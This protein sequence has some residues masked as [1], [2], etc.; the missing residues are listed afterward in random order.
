M[1]DSQDAEMRTHD[2]RNALAAMAAIAAGVGLASEASAQIIKRTD[3]G[4]IDPFD[5]TNFVPIEP[6][7][8][9]KVKIFDGT[10]EAEVY[11]ASLAEKKRRALLSNQDAKVTVE[12][13]NDGGSLTF[14]T[15]ALT[16][17]KG[18][19][20]VTVDYMRFMQDSIMMDGKTAGRAKVGVGLRVIANI[21]T[22]KAGL[23]LNGLFPIGFNASTDALSGDLEV[24]TIGLNSD[25][26]SKLITTPSELNQ[27]SI[28]KAL[29][30]MGAVRVLVDAET[31]ESVPHILAVSRN[32]RNTPD[33]IKFLG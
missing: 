32:V 12:K 19:Y 11:W 1:T 21:N 33:L 7:Q 29:E 13:V 30:A 18:R 28:T 17:E 15:G 6:I 4:G 8:V 25:Q 20:R 14:L 3:L 23:N 22:K 24:K 9:P 31:T 2:R 27:T 16:G 26:I 10:T 5:P